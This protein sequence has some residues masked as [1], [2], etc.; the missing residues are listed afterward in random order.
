MP[1]IHVYDQDQP[2]VNLLQVN[3]RIDTNDLCTQVAVT[4]VCYTFL[5]VIA[6]CVDVT[7]S[8]IDIGASANIPIVG[9]VSLGD[10]K[11]TLSN[12]K[13]SLGINIAVAES[14][15]IN[16]IFLALAINVFVPHDLCFM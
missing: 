11:L 12:P 13:C 16:K 4:N 3:Q 9:K 15:V 7:A 8:S 5:G 6:L 1:I 2:K 14:A 10:C